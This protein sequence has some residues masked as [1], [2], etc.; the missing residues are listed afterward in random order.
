M[1]DDGP[2]EADMVLSIESTIA[3]PKR[4]SLQHAITS[5]DLI[6]LRL[7]DSGIST[8]SESAEV[9]QNRLATGFDLLE[10]LPPE[11]SLL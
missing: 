4:G 1:T 5:V 11:N 9:S 7:R 2:L 6:Y 8:K 3:H 10:T